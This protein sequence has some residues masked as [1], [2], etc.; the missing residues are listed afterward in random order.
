LVFCCAK[1][2]IISETDGTENTVFDEVG[3]ARDE[4]AVSRDERKKVQDGW[5]K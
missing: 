5:K 4:R 1:I 3:P 2:V